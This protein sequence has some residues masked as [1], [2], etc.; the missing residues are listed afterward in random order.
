MFS[1]H[2][3]MRYIHTSSSS[4][5]MAL[6]AFDLEEAETRLNTCYQKEILIKSERHML[7]CHCSY[8]EIWMYLQRFFEV[9]QA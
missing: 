4:S 3:C 2:K 9:T 7:T 5:L 6:V 1:L 8:F